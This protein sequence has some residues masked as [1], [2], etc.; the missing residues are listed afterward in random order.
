MDWSLLPED[1]LHLVAGRIVIHAD[2]IRFRAVC[3]S[4]HFAVSP[5]PRHLP[6]QLPFLIFPENSDTVHNLYSITEN[7]IYNLKFPDHHHFLGSSHGWLILQGP[8]TALSLL[9]PFTRSKVHLPPA[10]AIPN[11]FDTVSPADIQR[12][13]DSFEHRKQSTSAG[14]WSYFIRKA[15]LCRDESS[16]GQFVSIVFP[17]AGLALWRPGCE[18]W[19]HAGRYWTFADAEFYKGQLFAIT[20]GGILSTIDFSSPI[21]ERVLVSSPPFAYHD[22]TV[23][24]VDSGEELMLVV[25]KYINGD[26]CHRRTHQFEVFMLELDVR[27]SRWSRMESLG[28]KI[29]FVERGSSISLPAAGLEGCKGNCIYFSDDY[30]V[31]LKDHVKTPDVGVFSMEDGNVQQLECY[32]PGTKSWR[33]FPTWIV[34]Y[35]W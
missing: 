5:R 23:Y 3:T 17:K 18:S 32:T 10:T 11:L 20:C 27:E 7:K 34:P 29:L 24:L 16:V 28:D 2:Y 35:L 12:Y 15:K 14:F 21:K 13:S 26:L 19:I 8:S 6:P 4:W 33:P 30:D 25:R 1:L 9:N 31:Y 22:N